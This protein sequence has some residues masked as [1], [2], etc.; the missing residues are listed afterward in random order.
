MNSSRSSLAKKVGFFA[1]AVVLVGGAVFYFKGN[2]GPESSDSEAEPEVEAEEVAPDVPAVD[3]SGTSPA[4][5]SL[6]EAPMASVAF[7]RESTVAESSSELED[8]TGYGFAYNAA[9][10]LDLDFSTAWCSGDVDRDTEGPWA[11]GLGLH[12]QSPPV[13]GTIVGI[14]PGFARDETIYYQNNR[15]KELT[16]VYGGAGRYQEKFQFEDDYSMQF[17]EWPESHEENSFFLYVTEIYPGSKYDDTCIA[18][19]DLWSEWVKTR[20]AEAAMNYYEQ[21]KKASALRPVRVSSV[22]FSLTSA[23]DACGRIDLTELASDSDAG[24]YYNDKDSS[25]DLIGPNNLAFSAIL[26]ESARAGDTF[27][28]KLVARPR[29]DD[30]RRTPDFV[31]FG[32]WY[33]DTVKAKACDDGKL[34]LSHKFGENLPT[35]CLF[36]SCFAEFYFNDRLVGRSPAFSWTQ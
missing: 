22:Q 27:L 25:Y 20:D 15:I 8:D 6:S 17:F 35:D 14:V 7:S 23:L 4:P 13:A 24:V 36:G 28:M 2:L 33:T 21:Y 29:F 9:N 10:V 34:Y 11:G 18:E 5:S 19:V 3:V 26:N 31:D 16:V 12:F 1:L 32:V 30:I